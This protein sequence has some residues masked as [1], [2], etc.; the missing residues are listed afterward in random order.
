MS[1]CDTCK[2]WEDFH[3]TTK[4][5]GACNNPKLLNYDVYPDGLS[6]SDQDIE[7]QRPNTGPKFGCVHHEEK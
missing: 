2:W 7:G 4:K 5:A 3:L 1:T 6:V